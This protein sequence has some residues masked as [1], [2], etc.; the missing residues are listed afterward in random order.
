MEAPTILGHASIELIRTGIV[1]VRPEASLILFGKDGK[2]LWEA[3]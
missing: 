3:P 1:E 2:L